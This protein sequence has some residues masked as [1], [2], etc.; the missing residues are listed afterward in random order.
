MADFNNL[1][2]AQSL[3]RAAKGGPNRSSDVND[4]FEEILHDLAELYYF[5]N[6]TIIPVL[7]GLGA[8]GTYNDLNAV[9]AGLDGK[10]LL[11]DNDW[12]DTTNTFFY[13]T[14]QG[15][16]KTVK[17]TTLK[18]SQDSDTLFAAI[19]TINAR[20]GA[21]DTSENTNPAT[22]A[23]IENSLNYFIGIVRTINTTTTG[24]LTASGI[25]AGIADNSINPSTF[26]IERGDITLNAGL[27][28]TDISGIDVTAAFDYTGGEPATYD[29]QDSIW[30]VKEFVEDISGD[31]LGLD[32]DSVSSFA[33]SGLSGDSLKTHREKVGTGTVTTTNPHGL[34]VGDLS[35]ANSVTARTAQIADFDIKISGLLG[36]MPSGVGEPELVQPGALTY[37]GGYVYVPGGFTVTRVAGTIEAGGTTGLTL[38]IYRRRSS[39]NV[40]LY[41]GLAIPASN[42]GSATATGG[43]TNTDLVAGDLVFVSGF[44]G[45]G[46]NARVFVWGTPS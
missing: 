29:I 28:P 23:E 17:E 42:P 35:D 36:A 44:S 30:R 16:P 1:K 32:S 5:V 31:T 7:N 21:I 18:L 41:S 22:L 33:N 25:A 34:D 20:L 4:S 11:T 24:F 46:F 38:G 26:N 12:S 19:N 27:R 2:S 39:V 13:N 8:P 6:N 9:T 43:F 15:R 3:R 14:A 40:E 37:A 45:D 10:T